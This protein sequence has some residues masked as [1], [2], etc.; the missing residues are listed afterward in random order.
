M[1]MEPK[2]KMTGGNKIPYHSMIGDIEFK[3]V[4]FS[5]PTRP[6]HVCCNSFVEGYTISTSTKENN[7]HFTICNIHWKH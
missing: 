2:M 6:D 7:I 1:S 5:Y 4:N 3:D